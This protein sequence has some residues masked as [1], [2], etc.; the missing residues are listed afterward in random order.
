MKKIIILLLLL[1]LCVGLCA[2]GA[3]EPALPA[4]PQSAPDKETPTVS[5]NTEATTSGDTPEAAEPTE[6]T[7]IWTAEFREE[8]YSSFNV[9]A[10]NGEKITTWRE[11][12]LFGL[13]VRAV[14]EYP[15]GTIEDC[16]YYP[17][18][19]P[20]KIITTLP[21]GE[22]SEK[23]M[24]D[25]GYVDPET[26]ISYSGTMIYFK[27]TMADGWEYETFWDENGVIIRETSKS[28]DGVYRTTDYENGIT[29]KETSSNPNTGEYQEAEYFENRKQKASVYDNASTGVHQEEAYFENG[30]LKFLKI[31]DSMG[32]Q[33]EHYD[34][35][36]FCT[37]CY[38][39]TSNYEIELIADENGKL[40]KAVENGNV[41]EDPVA[42]S[43]YA[44]E[45]KFRE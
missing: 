15:S 6:E 37:Y 9:T 30:N 21:D 10:P 11:G 45:Y 1:S 18:G 8:D 39:K 17:S 33:E 7:N 25:S 28:N 41:T 2:C 20:Y 38:V 34:E 23:W 26:G 4:A 27:Q 14:T 32:T 31:I 13:E 35:D 44:Q 5:E 29:A 16:Y 19:H 24:L 43:Q 36:G 3:E 42:L 12:G 40:A 22:V